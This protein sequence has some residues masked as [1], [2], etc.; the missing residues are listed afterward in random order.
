MSD[1]TCHSTRYTE[2]VSD[3]LISSDPNAWLRPYW[4]ELHQQRFFANLAPELQAQALARAVEQ[5]YP[6]RAQEI[7]GWNPVTRRAMIAVL[8]QALAERRTART[9]ELWRMRKQGQELRCI[10]VHTVVGLDLRLVG[11]DDILRTQLCRDAPELTH[12]AG[13]WQRQLSEGGWTI[14]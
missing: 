11:A 3:V 13:Q 4:A 6:A 2:R 14:G 8:D 12:R 5:D 10:A 7:R 9:T 1:L